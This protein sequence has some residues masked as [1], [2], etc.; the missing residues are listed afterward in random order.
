MTRAARG[1]GR[2]YWTATALALA[3]CSA[4]A[5]ERRGDALP[6][7]IYA[8]TGKNALSPSASHARP[9]VYVPNSRSATVTVIDPVTYRVIRTFATGA[10][11]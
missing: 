3:A 5:Q 9:L 11:P 4:G 6:T 10:L 1:V 7:N 2:N 8:A